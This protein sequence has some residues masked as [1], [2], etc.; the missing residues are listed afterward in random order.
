M[1]TSYF[2]TIM[3]ASRWKLTLLLISI[4]FSRPV[5]VPG[6]TTNARLAWSQARIV[7]VQ[8]LIRSAEAQHLPQ[9]QQGALWAELALAYWNATDFVKAEDAYSKSLHLLKSAPSAAAQYASVLEDLASLY[10]SYGRVAD[11]ENLAKQA[12]ATRRKMDNP[13]DIA[14]S[15]LHL[16]NIA[17]VRHQFKKSEQ[18]SQRGMQTLQS[19]SNPPK[20]GMLSGFITLTYARCSR[21]HCSEGMSDAQQAVAFANRNFEPESAPIGFALETRGFAEWKS[22]ASQDGERDMQEAI[23][24]LQKTLAPADPRLGG[25]MLQ[26]RSYLVEADRPAEARDIEQRVSTMNRQAGVSCANCA[27]GVNTLVQGK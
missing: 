12:Y 6:Q 14:L 16:A 15:Q 2:R 11:A 1:L 25:V 24:I 26:Y 9:G 22:G 8:E 4:L 5:M 21:K 20:T 18:L 19:A 3:F 23:R 27:V 10:L 7:Q 13:I 17:L